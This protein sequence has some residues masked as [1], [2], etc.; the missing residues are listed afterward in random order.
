MGVSDTFPR[1]DGGRHRRISRQIAR[2]EQCGRYRL[3]LEHVL[4]TILLGSSLS[5]SGKVASV[6]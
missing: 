2:G 5:K 1:S 6:M 4:L 3:V